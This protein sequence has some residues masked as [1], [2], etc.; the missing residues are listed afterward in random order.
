MDS[1]L[2]ESSHNTITITD[3]VKTLGKQNQ[4]KRRIK[5]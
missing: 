4:R 3:N 5:N 1:E 2:R